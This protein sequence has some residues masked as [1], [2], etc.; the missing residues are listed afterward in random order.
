[1]DNKLL[2]KRKAFFLL[3]SSLLV[4]SFS[5]LFHSFYDDFVS[6]EK[7]TEK[8]QKRII[9][10]EAE[11]DKILKGLLT[12]LNTSGSRSDYQTLYDAL[13]DFDRKNITICIFESDSLVFWTDNNIQIDPVLQLNMFNNLPLNISN[14]W[15]DLRT[16]QDGKFTLLGFIKIKMT[17]PYENDYLSNRFASYINV[18]P[19]IKV[20]PYPAKHNI[21]NSEGEFLI[22]LDFSGHATIPGYIE[23]FLSLAFI[24]SYILLLAALHYGY[25]TLSC[26]FRNTYL[27]FIGHAVDILI[28]RFVLL[29][30]SFPDFI[31]HSRLFYPSVFASSFWVPSLGDLFLNLASLFAIG[32]A[33]FHT[34]HINDLTDI[35]SK[36]LK[37]AL[38]HL[39]ILF[40][41]A[42]FYWLT[43]SLHNLVINSSFSYNLADITSINAFSVAGFLCFSLYLFSFILFSFKPAIFVVHV[44]RSVW[45][46]SMVLGGYF[47]A[48]YLF[49]SSI[50][51][52][53]F[54]PLVFLALF[55]IL[56]IY[57][58]KTWQKNRLF[59]STVLY[60]VLFAIFSTTLLNRSVIEKE[61][62]NRIILAQDFLYQKDPLLEYKFNLANEQIRADSLLLEKLAAFP[63]ADNVEYQNNIDLIYQS[64]FPSFSAKSDVWLTL[65]DPRE[66]L[67]MPSDSAYENC[68]DY[69]YNAVYAFGE[70]TAFENLFFIDNTR[71]EDN[72]LGIIDLP[73]PGANLKLFVEIFNKYI[74]PRVGFSELLAEKSEEGGRNLAD[75]SY[76]RY[77]DG[78]QMSQLGSFFYPMKLGE[79]NL[80]DT[81]V[82]FLNLEGYN[83][84]Y[85]APDRENAIL[86]SRK[87]AGLIDL[88]A[89]FSY[90]SIFLGLLALIFF[91]LFR[92]PGSI[93]FTPI[94]FKK[95]MQLSITAIII[96][97]FLF[98]G[99]GSLFYIT[100]LNHNKNIS[101]LQEK[102]NSVLIELKH[103]LQK[104]DQLGLGSEGTLS[105]YLD[106]FS[107]VFFTDINVYDLKGQLLASSAKGIFRKGLAS[108]TM[109][110]SAYLNMHSLGKSLFIHEE[111]IGEY[112]YLSAYRPLRDDDSGVIAYLNLP[113]FARQD[114]LT[115]EITTF[116]VAFINVY[117]MLIAFS[118]YL[119]LVISNYITKPIELI[120]EKIGSLKFGKTGEKIEWKRQDE[121]G[122]LI[123]QYNRMVDELALSAELLAKS[124]RE[125]AWREMAKQIAHEIKNPLTPMKLSVQYLQKAWDEKVPDWDDR[126]KRFTNTIVEQINSLS[127]IASEFSDFAKMPRSNFREIDLAEI[128]QNAIGIFSESSRVKF[129]FEHS[130]QFLVL[131]DK[132]QMLRVFNNLIKNSVQAIQEPA[133]GL[134]KIKLTSDSVNHNILFSD[135]GKGIPEEMKEKV[136]Y[137]N[138]TTKSGGMG[139]GLAMVKS[140]IENAKGSIRFESQE[141]E[142]TTFFIT[143]PKAGA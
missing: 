139:L 60:I 27:L 114:E 103:K 68:Y 137:P 13:S 2:F 106:K 140:I 79:F 84:L 87:N 20:L 11:V 9:Q 12:D 117:V 29:Y 69:F 62:T 28:I 19:E 122:S 48:L 1:M 41:F 18:S 89:P 3:F 37:F 97:S 4:L 72:Y 55:F 112:T 76:C 16:I 14:G 52:F 127:I 67:E 130:G 135:N 46:I 23:T 26:Y 96:V 61:R 58:D 126:L 71:Y 81:G 24:L 39:A 30:F 102:S 70:E 36:V 25:K 131:A 94:S 45:Q 73:V 32:Y 31:D 124:E 111:K 129:E 8:I 85:Y 10:K 104:E 113:Y 86:I 115:N 133:D 33:F 142:G 110:S 120:R 35:R 99:V 64:Y 116:L 141:S 125:S 75:Y 47:I 74:S 119:A 34:L 118:V 63:F 59:T 136:F 138:F 132:E 53:D 51:N 101:I 92:G 121:I 143:L 49:S 22:G 105:G 91:I 80:P 93:K 128:I 54:Y 78:D 42:G 66:L 7:L 43:L 6:D 56:I 77:E 44:Y 21:Y 15:F 5:F 108:K 88:I 95:Q 100:T 134:I 90:I 38:A 98:V 57:I 83:H 123:S 40:I 109:N 107:Q 82:Y 17:F 65:C 50:P